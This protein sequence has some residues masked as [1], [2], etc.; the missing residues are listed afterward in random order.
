MRRMNKRTPVRTF[1]LLCG[2]LGLVLL[3]AALEY[4]PAMSRNASASSSTKTVTHLHT[5]TPSM[6]N[7]YKP[8]PTLTR[9]PTQIL[10]TAPL[11][12][13]QTQTDTTPA[14]ELPATFYITDITGHKQ[15]FG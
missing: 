3:V 10:P 11:I 6:V 1:Y 8:A 12:P 7:T 5:P 15:Y 4:R 14:P 2:L 9:T 13:T